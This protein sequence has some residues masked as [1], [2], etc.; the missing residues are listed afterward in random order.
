[1]FFPR[2]GQLEDWF[3]SWVPD[4][5]FSAGSGRG[6]V[7]AVPLTLTFISMWPMLTNPLILLV[8]PF[9]ISLGLPG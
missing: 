3:L 8:V 1:M 9:W 5:V 4:S 2:M 7:E 6:S